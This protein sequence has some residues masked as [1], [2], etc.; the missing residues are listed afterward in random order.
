MDSKADLLED[1][2]ELGKFNGFHHLT[3]LNPD[4]LDPNFDLNKL[5]RNVQT[6]DYAFDDFS[7][8]KPEWF[9]LQFAQANDNVRYFLIRDS[10][11][12]IVSG[13]LQAGGDA[14]IH[15]IIWD[16]NFSLHSDKLPAYELCDWLF[17]ELKVHR[18]SGPIPSYN[19][20]A[21]RFATAMGMKFEG[22][23]QEAVLWKGKYW[24][25]SMYGLLEKWYRQ[26]KEH[27]AL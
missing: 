14:T 12:F 19:K 1:K 27:I 10:G 17:Y 24:N 6:Q 21:P 3:W 16:R 18:V 13:N 4:K 22:E 26:R 11:I 15:F 8:D 9:L 23:M 25:V 7:R 20:L 2:R 5:W